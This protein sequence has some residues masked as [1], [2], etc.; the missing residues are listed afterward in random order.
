MEST[1]KI[2]ITRLLAVFFLS[3]M[4]L[5]LPAQAQLVVGR[6]YVA[7]EPVQLTDNP[8]KIEVIEFFSYACPHCNDLAPNINQW[9]AKLPSDV[10][11][12]RVPVGFNAPFYQLMA[13]LYYALEAI[14]ELQRL[15]AAVFNAIHVKGLK[16]VDDKSVAEWVTSQGVDAKKFSD[17]YNS[18]GVSTKTKRAD[19]LAQAARISGVPAIVVDGQYLVTG[20]DIKSHADLLGL[21]DKIIEKRRAERNSKKK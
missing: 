12:K 21:T 11:L 16:L 19:Q 9:A 17:A 4:T 3:L 7:I 20:K 13:K 15:D 1:M 6:D 8:A 18:F 5:A 14:G 2:S 10:V